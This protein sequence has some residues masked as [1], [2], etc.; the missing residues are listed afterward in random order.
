MRIARLLLVAHLCALAF[1]LA[2]MLVALPNPQA[3]ASD[4]VALRV[5]SLGMTYGGTTQILLGA[6]AV[7]VWAGLTIGWRRTAVFFVCS[8]LVSV[9]SELVGTGTGWP[10]GNYEYTSYLG[11]KVMDRVPFTIPLSWFFMGLTSYLLGTLLVARLGLRSRTAWSLLL[12]VWLLTAWDLVLDPAMADAGLRVQFWTWHQTGPY[13]GMPVQNFLGWSL[14]AFAFMALSRLIWGGD[15][16]VAPIA[17]R[18]G[19]PFTVYGANMVFAMV[20]NLSVGLWAPA[21][22]AVATGVLPTAF[23]SIGA[24]T[25]RRGGAAVPSRPLP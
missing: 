11:Y 21:V 25:G 10:F 20:L 14:T 3:W 2:G 7:A 19:F 4:P 17:A 13:F 24:S 15:L 22:L 5:F 12:G 18:S 9:T 23:A 16:E 1:G 6:T 8:T